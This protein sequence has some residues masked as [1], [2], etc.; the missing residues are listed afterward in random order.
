VDSFISRC[1]VL[2]GGHRVVQCT[3][4][5]VAEHARLTVDSWRRA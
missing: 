4:R 3:V 5:Y 2:P 1:W